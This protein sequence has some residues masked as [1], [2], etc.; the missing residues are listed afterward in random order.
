M[1]KTYLV[2]YINLMDKIYAI[3]IDEN[4]NL[5]FLESYL[6]NEER[7]YRIP[8]V[9]IDITNK[10]REE[11]IEINKNNFMKLFIEYLNENM[12]NNVYKDK[13]ELLADIE[14]FKNYVNTDI[15]LKD[16]LII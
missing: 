16:Y 3:T 13:D 11:L 6:E 2:S 7:K 9:N 10:T 8:N 5:N 1:N 14:K 15:E 12:K 4:K